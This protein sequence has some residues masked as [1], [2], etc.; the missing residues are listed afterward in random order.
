M[1]W[2][3]CSLFD[4]LNGLYLFMFADK[5]ALCLSIFK[6]KELWTYNGLSVEPLDT[7]NFNFTG[8]WTKHVPDKIDVCI[9]FL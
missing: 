7:S 5:V 3:H 6:Q 8:D 4:H 9:N 1:L 2:L